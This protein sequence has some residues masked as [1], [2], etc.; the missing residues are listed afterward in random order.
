MKFSAGDKAKHR[1]SAFL[2]KSGR[3]S[4]RNASPRGAKRL[5]GL[6]TPLEIHS[7]TLTVAAQE[8][9]D[10]RNDSFTTI[11]LSKIV[12]TFCIG[13]NPAET[14]AVYRGIRFI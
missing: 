10:R 2:A 12:L 3:R 14:A 4:R 1:G 9:I 11:H 5:C 13:I 6:N 8:L 7:M